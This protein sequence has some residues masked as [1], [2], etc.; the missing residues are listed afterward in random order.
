MQLRNGKLAMRSKG[1]LGLFAA[2][3]YNA[4]LKGILEPTLGAVN[5]LS[6]RTL[7]IRSL[8][9][10]DKVVYAIHTYYY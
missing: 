3:I 5:W 10:E 7:R 4:F 8:T 2:D 6:F 1:I 9:M